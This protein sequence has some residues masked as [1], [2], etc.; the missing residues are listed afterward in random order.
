MAVRHV[1]AYKMN[2]AVTDALGISHLVVLS[3]TLKFESVN[4]TATIE[5]VI[6]NDLA[7][8]ISEKLE[9]FRKP[10]DPA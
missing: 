7:G 3:V 8:K 10:E 2:K 5:V 1:D 9:Q 6:D 4:P